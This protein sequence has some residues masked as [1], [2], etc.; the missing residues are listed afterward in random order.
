MWTTI[1][2]GKVWN[3]I[4]CNKNKKGEIFWEE[5]Q[6][7]PLFDRKKQIIYFVAIKND[8]TDRVKAENALKNYNTYLI[9]IINSLPIALIVTSEKGEIIDLWANEKE[10]SWINKNISGKSIEELFEDNNKKILL[11]ALLNAV[12]SINEQNFIVQRLD[13][14]KKNYYDIRCKGVK[15]NENSLGLIVINDIT[16]MK[17]YEEKLKEIILTKDKFF[18]ILAHDLRNPFHAI[19]GI[20][21][22]ILTR[23]F[24]EKEFDDLLKMLLQT[25]QKTYELLENLLEWSRTQTGKIQFTPQL[26]DLHLL[27]NEIVKIFEIYSN[28]KNIKIFNNIPENTI[29]SID[30]N[31]MRTVFRNLISN[32]IKFTYDDGSVSINLVKSDDN[33]IIIS[34]KDTGVGIDADNLKKLFIKGGNSTIGTN[35]ERGTGLGLMLCKEF[36]ELHGGHIT[37]ESEKGKG[38]TV[39]INLPLKY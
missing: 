7:F 23:S 32:A 37:I 30:I 1:N 28:K 15:I 26:Y 6:I 16:L 5:Q 21:E 19:M 8:V 29:T 13:N 10:F 18:S 11:D 4:F 3:G 34:V 2:A 24:N 9:S 33:S 36:I 35:N 27:I 22:L 14:E 17:Q 20:I 12:E 39:L 25:T 31:L 38:T